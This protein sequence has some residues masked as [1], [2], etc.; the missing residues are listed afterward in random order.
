MPHGCFL[1]LVR[2]SRESALAVPAGNHLHNGRP[3][4]PAIDTPH[5]IEQKIRRPQKGMN[6]KRRSAS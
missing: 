3:A 5:G 6:S 4:A 2:I 1:L